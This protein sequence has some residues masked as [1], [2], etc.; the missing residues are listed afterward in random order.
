[1]T[2]LETLHILSLVDIVIIRSPAWLWL[3]CCYKKELVE[4]ITVIPE[5]TAVFGSGQES[6]D[7]VAISICGEAAKILNPTVEF[8]TIQ[9]YVH[10]KFV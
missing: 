5:A 8:G 6:A 10:T 2:V 3:F 4:S 7:V 1:M 9:C